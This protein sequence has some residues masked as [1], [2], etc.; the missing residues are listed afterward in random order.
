MYLPLEKKILSLT[1][2]YQLN[3]GGA[4]TASFCSIRHYCWKWA[5]QSHL[6]P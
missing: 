1:E 4:G 5:G 6:R 3:L 2:D